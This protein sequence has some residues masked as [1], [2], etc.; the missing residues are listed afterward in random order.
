MEMA[1]IELFRADQRMP[2]PTADAEM[3]RESNGTR[4]CVFRSPRLFILSLARIRGN[5]DVARLLFSE[6]RA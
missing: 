3:R 5:S 1:A 4:R 6:N 2:P